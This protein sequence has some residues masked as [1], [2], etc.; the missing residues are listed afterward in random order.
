MNIEA[1]PKKLK[2]KKKNFLKKTID[3]FQPDL[4]CTLIFF[5]PQVEL[6]CM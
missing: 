4:S 6:F 3:S 1:L 5:L 2:K